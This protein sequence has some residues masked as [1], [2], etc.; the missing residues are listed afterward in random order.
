MS[1]ATCVA[2]AVLA[3]SYS[4]DAEDPLGYPCPTMGRAWIVATVVFSVPWV[5]TAGYVGLRRRR[6]SSGS[7]H[8]AEQT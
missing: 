4:R 5:V 8:V 1:V 6:S 3:V 2:L 7:G